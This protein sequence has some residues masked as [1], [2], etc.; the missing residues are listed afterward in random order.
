VRSWWHLG[1][2]CTCLDLPLPVFAFLSLCMPRSSFFFASL[3]SCRFFWNKQGGGFYVYGGSI[4]LVSCSIS[5]NTAVS[6][7]CLF[8]SLI[9]NSCAWFIFVTFRILCSHCPSSVLCLFGFS[10]AALVFRVRFWRHLECESTCFD[11]PLPVFAFF[12]LSACRAVFVFFASLFSCRFFWNKQ[13]GGFYVYS[14]SVSL[15]SCSISE[16]TAVS[17]SCLFRSLI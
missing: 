13:G 9:W 8:R 6:S 11:L 2:E 17:S 5:G 10:A 12:F 4:S 1:C 16:N 7:S 3:F 14:G 15:V